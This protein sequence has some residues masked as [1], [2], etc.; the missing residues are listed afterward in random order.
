MKAAAEA[1]SAASHLTPAQRER[2]IN[3]AASQVQLR[4]VQWHSMTTGCTALLCL[5]QTIQAVWH[6][7]S[8][9]LQAIAQQQAAR[10]HAAQDAATPEGPPRAAGTYAPPDWDAAPDGYE[11]LYHL[12]LTVQMMPP[13]IIHTQSDTKLPLSKHLHVT[14]NTETICL[15]S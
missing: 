10:A 4:C 5:I 13:C 14:F 7:V 8:H 11:L 6:L 12:Q 2:A 15:V 3:E 1:A 9:V